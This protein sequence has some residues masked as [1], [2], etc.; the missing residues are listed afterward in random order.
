MLSAASAHDPGST[1][2]GRGGLRPFYVPYN[3]FTNAGLPPRGRFAV[4]RAWH[5]LRAAGRLGERELRRAWH[6][7]F[8][9]GDDRGALAVGRLG[10]D[11]QLHDRPRVKPA[12]GEAD[13]TRMWRLVPLLAIALAL[14]AP[15][16]SAK[17]K[18]APSWAKP[19]IQQVAAAGLM[20]G[21]AADFRPDDPLTAT[22]LE[23]VVAAFTGQEPQGSPLLAW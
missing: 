7:R 4:A 21:D 2:R 8:E 9:C 13:G 18:A 22:E 1:L 12:A 5:R 23:G 10:T 11:L 17:S 19:Q 3:G 20:G 14:A 15:A 16:A 6:R